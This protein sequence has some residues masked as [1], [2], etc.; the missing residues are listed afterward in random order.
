MSSLVELAPSPTAIELS[1]ERVLHETPAFF[2]AKRRHPKSTSAL[3][4]L[5][6]VVVVVGLWELLI[7]VFGL[8]PYA[9]P[10]PLSVAEQLRSS[11]PII[12]KALWPTSEE[13]VLAFLLSVAVGVPLGIVLVES[14]LLG[15]FVDPII[16][17]SQAVPKVAVAPLFILWWGFGLFP[18]V[19]IGFLI[20]FFPVVVSTS[21][22]L[23]SVSGEV[24]DLARS[25]GASRL[26]T[27]RLVKLPTALPNIFGGLRVA[28]T[29]AVIGA[30]VAEF[31]GA[32]QGL[33]Y[34]IVQAEG[35]LDTQLVFATVVVL[36]VLGILAYKVVELG[37]YALI[38]WHRQKRAASAE[39]GVGLG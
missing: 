17:G 37:E 2:K 10:T 20:A 36:T 16:V 11:W 21:V 6:S 28:M 30:V 9:L 35:R 39:S 33:G 8:K 24:I 32:D 29:L 3:A 34:L 23:R 25:A 27:L 12:A 18:K 4:V 7:V 15:R 19:I 22:G 5:T 38:P 14:R 13:I 1:E 26:K 31:V